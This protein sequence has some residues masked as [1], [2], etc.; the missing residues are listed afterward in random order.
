M[1]KLRVSKGSVEFISSR[2]P[3]H[4]RQIAAKIQD[5]R[6]NPAPA[7]SI[8]LKGATQY[9][10]ADC[11]EYRIIYRLED[12]TLFVAIIGKRYDDEVYR[13]FRKSFS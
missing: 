10:R 13:R 3:K 4:Q 9:R 2:P 8:C 7:D 5:L 1:L 12:D 11:G 6:S